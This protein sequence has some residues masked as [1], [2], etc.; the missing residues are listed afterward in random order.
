[1]IDQSMHGVFDKPNLPH[2]ITIMFIN[3]GQKCT[4]IQQDRSAL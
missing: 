4:V 1:M 3:A 2:K